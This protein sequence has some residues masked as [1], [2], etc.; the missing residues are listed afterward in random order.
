MG[1]NSRD[2]ELSTRKDDSPEPEVEED[3]DA[4]SHCRNRD[5]VLIR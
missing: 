4:E 5:D 1:F 2:D 3:T